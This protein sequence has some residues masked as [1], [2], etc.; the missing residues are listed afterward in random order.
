MKNRYYRAGIYPD[1][2][3]MYDALWLDYPAGDLED[4][5]RIA[6]EFAAEHGFYRVFLIKELPKPK[7]E[8]PSKEPAEYGCEK[9]TRSVLDRFLDHFRMVRLTIGCEDEPRGVL[10]GL[11]SLNSLMFDSIGCDEGEVVSFNGLG[12]LIS[13]HDDHGVPFRRAD[14]NHLLADALK[15]HIPESFCEIGQIA[16]MGFEHLEVFG[17]VFRQLF[18]GLIVSVNPKKIG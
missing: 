5:R 14:E 6:H 15:V 8:K 9:S 17:N 2:T 16:V 12:C 13:R 4:A 10:D 1:K 11:R 7:D 3:F 18:H